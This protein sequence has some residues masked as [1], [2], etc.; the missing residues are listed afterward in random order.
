MKCEKCGFENADSAA[1][2]SEC[3]AALGHRCAQC[4]QPLKEGM[5]FCPR[6]GV[7][8][9]G[10]RVCPVC[11]TVSE[12]DA[13]HCSE[14][15]RLLAA[16][17]SA[18]AP[19]KAVAV[20]APPARRPAKT[21][22]KRAQ[23]LRLLDYVRGGIVTALAIAAFVCSFFGVFRIDINNAYLTGS[24]RVSSLDIIE[25]AF[26]CVDPMPAEDR[27]RDFQAFLRDELPA[28]VYTDIAQGS[29]TEAETEK[30]LIEVT[31]KYNVLKLVTM[32]ELID[33][34]PTY[35]LKLGF[36]A[37]FAFV[38]IGLS[39]AFLV[40][41]VISLVYLVTGRRKAV[42]TTTL[43]SLLAP[44]AAVAM[45]ALNGLCFDGGIGSGILTVLICA[46]CAAAVSAIY[47]LVS[48]EISFTGRSMFAF[49]SAGINA[50]LII[51]VLSLCV[52]SVLT[53]RFG[54][55]PAFLENAGL[56]DY[57]EL[58]V[59][60]Y[61]AADLAEAWSALRLAA[62]EELV[63]GGAEEYFTE[64][65]P[66]IFDLPAYFAKST[67]SPAL[68]GVLG[69]VIGFE[70][71]LSAFGILVFVMTV[72]LI[73]VLC[74]SLFF[75]LKDIVSGREHVRMS[76]NIIALSVAVIT[77]ACT[78]AYA[79]MVN[80]TMRTFAD[81]RYTTGVSATQIVCLVFVAVNLVQSIVFRLL[82]AGGRGKAEAASSVPAAPSDPET[83]APTFPS[84]RQETAVQPDTSDD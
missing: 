73:A 78:V 24:F 21:K 56:T 48:R 14:C 49:L 58:R 26:S 44:L 79:L 76:I 71:A 74:A 81:I 65:V 32:K 38:I 20:A 61:T 7:R 50:A 82:H 67:V 84:G 39:A 57:D 51:V 6:C 66:E 25:G 75:S 41:S 1:F 53:L 40:M 45:T 46:L 3:G 47:S 19:P 80:R 62:N 9:D 28:D 68:T 8:C 70:N 2:C 64:L 11:G 23:V 72:V 30:I 5:K 54:M 13:R 55:S 37:F 63:L 36:L 12:A 34:T 22:G 4:G 52:S 42:R 83:E 35:P 59:F 33:V 29:V 16:D 17:T 77:F 31:E 27:L 10:K 18:G 15:G 60:R 69:S 43:L